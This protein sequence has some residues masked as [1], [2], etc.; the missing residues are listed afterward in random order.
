VSPETIKTI[1]KL[2]LLLLGLGTVLSWGFD[3]G[4]ALSFLIGGV[5]MQ[6]NFWLLKK[7][8]GS[9]LFRTEDPRQGKRRAALWFVMKGIFFLILLSGLFIHYPIQPV[10]FTVGVSLLLMTCMIVSL[11]KSLSGSQSV[12]LERK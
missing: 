2:N 8:V 11:S 1:E 10:S 7:V 12:I 6:L 5:V 9:L 3:I 4:H